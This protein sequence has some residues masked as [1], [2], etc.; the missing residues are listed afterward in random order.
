MSIWGK[1][2]SVGAKI[3]SQS[4]LRGE[5]NENNAAADLFGWMKKEYF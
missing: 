5:G 1:L 3:C 2:L 4:R